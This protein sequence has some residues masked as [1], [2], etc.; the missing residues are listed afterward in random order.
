MRIGKIVGTLVATRKDEHLVGCKLL[1]TQPVGADGKPFGQMLVA[2]DTV[3][4]GIG[5]LV[6]FAQGSPAR[7]AARK[8]DAP[9]DAAVVAIIDNMDISGSL[10]AGDGFDKP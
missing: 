6:V 2:V 10:I 8:M 5:E 9:I 7:M 4:A 3:G 1:L